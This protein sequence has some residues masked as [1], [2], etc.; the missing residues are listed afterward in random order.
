ML[1]MVFLN[2]LESVDHHKNLEKA[3]IRRYVIGVGLVLVAIMVIINIFNIHTYR[4]RNRETKETIHLVIWFSV[5]FKT[6]LKISNKSLR[7]II[8]LILIFSLENDFLPA[9]SH[10]VEIHVSSVF[11]CIKNK[12]QTFAIKNEITCKM[13][14]IWFVNI[15]NTWRINQL[16]NPKPFWRF[17][18]KCSLFPKEIQEMKREF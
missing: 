16:T 18:N 11:I 3:Y 9:K 6:L 8:S 4:K 5:P 10:H 2:I 7:M 14:S 12:K 13:F 15:S 17:I 1:W